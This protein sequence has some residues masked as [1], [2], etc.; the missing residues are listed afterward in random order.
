MHAVDEAGHR[1][2]KDGAVGCGSKFYFH[3]ISVNSE[4]QFTYLINGNNYT[5]QDGGEY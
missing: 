3:H 2:G 4:S 5:S 1:V